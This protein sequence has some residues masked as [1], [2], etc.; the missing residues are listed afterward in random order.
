M[1]RKEAIEYL[2]SEYDD[3]VCDDDKY[4]QE[5]A[6]ALKMAIN[7]LEV[8]EKYQLEWERVNDEGRS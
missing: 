4:E 7:S 5:W 6:E 1:T 2:K 8:D 3:A